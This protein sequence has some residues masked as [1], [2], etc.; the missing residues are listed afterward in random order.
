M[1]PYIKYTSLGFQLLFF[2]GAGYFLGKWGGPYIGI[3]ESTAAAFGA[4]IFLS[5]GLYKLVR[6]VMQ[7]NQ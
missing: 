3:Q 1:S 4:L 5:L 7:E 2:I 6:E